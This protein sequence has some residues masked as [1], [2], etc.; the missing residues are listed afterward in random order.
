[1]TATAKSGAAI[2]GGQRSSNAN[3][4]ITGGTITATI[5]GTGTG[6]AIGGGGGSTGAGNHEIGGNLS[7]TI[8][9]GDLVLRTAI[10]AG[11]GHGG[12]L[13]VP[14][15]NEAVRGS[16]TITGGKILVDFNEGNG[17]G[18]GWDNKVVP[19]LIIDEGADITA[20]GRKRTAFAG[21]Y[22]GDSVAN[23]E[24]GFNKGD[25]Y[26]I[27]LN[28]PDGLLKKDT[29][30]IV[31][32]N[33]SLTNPVKT[34]TAPVDSGMLSFTVGAADSLDFNVYVQT[35]GG[36]RQLARPSQNTT[37]VVYDSNQ[38]YSVN[39][40]F[41]Y[42]GNGHVP[43]NYYRSLPVKVADGAAAYHLVKEK[44]TDPNGRPI[45]KDD[46]L[47]LVS[48]GNTY[49]KAVPAVAGY[50]GKGHTWDN[51]PA[52]G[53]Y[54]AGS[55]DERI[56]E[57]R[58]VYFVY[59][60][61]REVGVTVTKTV[62]GS[63]ASSIKAFTF[64]VS[65]T[66]GGG[67][68]LAEGTRFDAEGDA[69]LTNGSLSLD[70]NGE[71]VFTLKH[72]QRITIKGV[73]SDVMMKVVESDYTGYEMSYTDSAGG[74]VS[75][76]EMRFTAVGTDARRF[77]FTNTRIAVVPTGIDGDVGGPEALLLAAALTLLTGTAVMEAGKRR[78][79]RKGG[80]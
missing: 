59:E 70:S 10:G 24:Y 61:Y 57:D 77:D 50:L 39:Q 46:T 17:I 79:R 29:L 22:A 41:K 56:T 19:S 73:P 40:T 48:Y 23:H 36:M 76:E 64:T 34:M 31:V 62:K 30:I 25:G 66:N 35:P 51:P 18:T 42:H 45:G 4:K 43:D 32:A 5:N 65:F 75:T 69:A 47:E 7:I 33:G 67:V 49:S 1:M 8:T 80:R 38:I 15:H 21:I 54:M 72:G 26:Y 71:A 58:V 52:G 3:I 16:I 68:P 60:L 27:N 11:I 78:N 9:G 63:Y 55:P 53:V 28:F 6:A 2:G 13:T 12:Y 20:F 37:P 14:T 74:G 44:Y